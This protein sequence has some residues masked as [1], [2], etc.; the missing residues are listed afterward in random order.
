MSQSQ[1]LV[2]VTTHSINDGLQDEYRRQQDVFTRFVEEN[3]PDLLHFDVYTNDAED[4]VT[5]L[6]VFA[7]AAA[8]DFHMQVSRDRIAEGLEI[9]RTA[10]LEVY[11]TPG[12]ALQQVLD[13]NRDMGVPVSIKQ[14]LVAG[15]DRRVAV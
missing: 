7:D 15:F 10:R 4:E 6:F 12:P 1:P 14:H 5:F 8:G 13:M 3:E 11:G 2:F 9:T